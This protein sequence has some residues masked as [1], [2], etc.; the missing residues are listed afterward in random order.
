MI[1]PITK[2]KHQTY[3]QKHMFWPRIPA[4][5]KHNFMRSFFTTSLVEPS[6]RI[7]QKSSSFSF[8]THQNTS[9]DWQNIKIRESNRSPYNR[10][11]SSLKYPTTLSLGVDS[12]WCYSRNTTTLASSHSPSCTRMSSY[13]YTTKCLKKTLVT[14]KDKA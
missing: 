12:Q 5:E 8:T 14:W 10:D 11:F 3:T 6:V 7:E 1:K 4:R 13:A 2:L 9:H